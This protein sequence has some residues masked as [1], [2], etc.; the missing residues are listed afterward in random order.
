MEKE[1]MGDLKLTLPPMVEGQDLWGIYVG[2][3]PNVTYEPR[4]WYHRAIYRTLMYFHDR[5]ESLWHWLWRTAQPF[6]P[7]RK[8]GYVDPQ[9]YAYV[10]KDG[11]SH[12]IV[13][14]GR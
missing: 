4:R 3:G 14:E 13:G 8:V 9:L 12:P 7:T 10:D 1:E 11:N 2:G 5:T 6:A